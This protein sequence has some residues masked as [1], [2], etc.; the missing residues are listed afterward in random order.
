M[1]RLKKTVGF[2]LTLVLLFIGAVNI[3]AEDAGIMC[4]PP[5]PPEP[6]TPVTIHKIVGTGGFTLRDHDGSQLDANTIKDLGNNAYEYAGP[7]VIFTIW[8]VKADTTLE[9]LKDKSDGQ[10]NKEFSKVGDIHAGGTINLTDGRYYIRETKQPDTFVEQLGVP[11]I[12]DIPALD[13]DGNRLTCIHIYPKNILVDKPEIDKDVREKD[14]DYAGFDIGEEFSYFIYPTIPVGFENY[15]KFEIKEELDKRLDY[16]GAIS[17]S[18]NGVALALDDD[19]TVSESE[20]GAAGGGFT[21]AFTEAGLAKLAKGRPADGARKY[22]EIR[23]NARINNTAEMGTE[24]ENNAKINYKHKFTKEKETDIPKPKRP[25][26]HTG[27]RKFIKVDAADNKYNPLLKDAEFVVKKQVEGGFL[28]MKQDEM[29][30]ISWIQ[31]INEATILRL[32][33]QGKF[34]VRGLAYGDKGQA[35]EYWLEEIKTPEGYIK[36]KDLKFE[37]KQDSY[38]CETKLIKVVNVKK[39]RIPQTGGIGSLVFSVTG[40]GLMGA[41]VL[42]LRKKGRS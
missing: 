19:Y 13:D 9:S 28:Y 29:G 17:V 26:V 15:S 30:R 20:I 34:E 38:D 16:M 3:Y 36:M 5:W 10:L 21:L 18:Y 23:F 25:K 2:L 1:K 22:L 40:L 7:E 27:G 32:D 39:P 8:K 42:V 14:N 4:W 35:F 11:T 37:V 33:D 12:L 41:A 24:I 31:D 6:E